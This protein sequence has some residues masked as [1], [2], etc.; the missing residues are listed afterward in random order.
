MTTGQYVT[1]IQL[2]EYVTARDHVYVHCE[3]YTNV[4]PE[5]GEKTT[6]HTHHVHRSSND[7]DNQGANE[8][9]AVTVCPNP[10]AEG[11]SVNCVSRQDRGMI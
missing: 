10:T 2:P 9:P 6:H 11:V 7:A 3:V 5:F 4:A 1:G 8:K